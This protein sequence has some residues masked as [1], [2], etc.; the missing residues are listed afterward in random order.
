MLQKINHKS[1]VATTACVQKYD[2]RTIFCC[3]LPQTHNN[4]S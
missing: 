4:S 2:G 1:P 3:D